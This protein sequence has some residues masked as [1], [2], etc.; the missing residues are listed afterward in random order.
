MGAAALSRRL[1][2]LSASLAVALAGCREHT[3][4]RIG[5]AYP[6]SLSDS[7]FFASIRPAIESTGVNVSTW[8]VGG[9]TPWS[10]IQL[11][12]DQGNL[13]ADDPSIVAVV[14]HS[15][16]REALLG[17]TVYNARGVPNVIP[18]ATSSR[19]AK[20]GPWTFM[21]VPD[22]SVQGE[23]ISNYAMDSLKAQRISVLYLGDEYG[24]GLRDGVRAGLGRRGARPADETMIPAEECFSERSGVL[25]GSIVRSAMR[26]ANPDVF[27]VTSGNVNGWCIADLIHVASPNTWVV[28][29]D[30]MDGARRLPDPARGLPDRPLRIVKEKIRGVEFWEPGSDSVNR[31]FVAR[32]ERAVHHVPD[33]SQA[34]QY[35]AYMLLAAAVEE[36]GPSR[37]AVRE[38]LES[39]GRTRPA[40]QG[41]T[42][43]IAFNRPRS[44]ILRMSGPNL[45]A[46]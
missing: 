17:A 14:G 7:V 42:G 21:L 22:D 29:S 33:A 2:P 4:V 19:L 27:V 39:L 6:R 32:V 24:I 5:D 43:P 28:F 46:Q 45:T 12:T 9:G 26:R 30:G 20:T 11:N 25:Y 15:G 8:T 37:T 34:L 41:V 23:F 13:F 35:D 18:N 10:T 40:W 1:L 31:A 38:W 16:S 3:P 36:V 44:E